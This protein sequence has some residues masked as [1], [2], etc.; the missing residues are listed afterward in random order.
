[1]SSSP[2]ISFAFKMCKFKIGF[3]RLSFCRFVVVVANKNYPS[4]PSGPHSPFQIYRCPS[5]H[6]SPKQLSVNDI[7]T[8]PFG[9]V[10]L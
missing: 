9:S 8:G 3:C 4:I 10:F 2:R 7:K 5:S 1:M 6:H